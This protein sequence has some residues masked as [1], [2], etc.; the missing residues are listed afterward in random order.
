MTVDVEKNTPLLD[1]GDGEAEVFKS[2]FRNYAFS[3]LTTIWFSAVLLTLMFTTV[4]YVE[5]GLAAQKETQCD[6]LSC[7][8]VTETCDS[9][10]LCCMVYLDLHWCD[11]MCYNHTI[12]IQLGSSC[13]HDGT[14]PCS[15]FSNTVT[16]YYDSRDPEDTVS[17]DS[18]NQGF[19]EIMTETLLSFVLLLSGLGVVLGV[20]KDLGKCK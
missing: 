17:L 6:V 19:S 14:N 8:A 9:S 16:C 5:P 7:N 1:V 18:N 10:T 12:D 15:T 13:S 4:Y 11:R 3:I 20:C 2:Q